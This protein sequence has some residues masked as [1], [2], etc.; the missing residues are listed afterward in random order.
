MRSVVLG[1]AAGRGQRTA[2]DDDALFDQAA[3]YHR[4][5]LSGQ[6]RL[7]GDLDAADP[8]GCLDRAEHDV[9]VVGADPRQVGTAEHD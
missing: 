7:L 6:P 9:Y 4:H 5:G 8:V 2:L 3:D 1:F